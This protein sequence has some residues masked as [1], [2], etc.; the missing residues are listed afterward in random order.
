MQ[1]NLKKNEILD[2]F[3]SVLYKLHLTNQLKKIL[4]QV[5]SCIQLRLKHLWMWIWKLLIVSKEHRFEHS[6]PTQSPTTL[7]SFASDSQASRTSLP[8]LCFGVPSASNCLDEKIRTWYFYFFASCLLAQH[9]TKVLNCVFAVSW[10]PALLISVCSTLLMLPN[11][12]IYK[13]HPLHSQK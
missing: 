11:L 13:Q 10:N 1:L 3:A 8:S 5:L 6:L 2:Y 7:Q 9:E 4:P 12:K